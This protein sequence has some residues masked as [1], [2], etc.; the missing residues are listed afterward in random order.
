MDSLLRKIGLLYFWQPLQGLFLLFG[1]SSFLT[2]CFPTIQPQ[3]DSLLK[4][5]AFQH[6]RE[7]PFWPLK[8]PYITINTFHKDCSF[9]DQR[10]LC[11]SLTS[12]RQNLIYFP[13]SLRSSRMNPKGCCLRREKRPDQAW[14]C[15]IAPNKNG[16]SIS[17]PWLLLLVSW[18]QCV[19]MKCLLKQRPLR[20]RPDWRGLCRKSVS[21]V[22]VHYLWESRDLFRLFADVSWLR[23]FFTQTRPHSHARNKVF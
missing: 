14:F 21:L 17:Q 22:M 2:F 9:S 6:L 4:G 1:N 8:W 18:R 20:K 10:S 15:L 12:L 7:L 19:L 11:I 5:W 16:S 23:P 3:L 13:T